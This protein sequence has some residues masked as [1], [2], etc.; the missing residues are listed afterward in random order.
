M[1]F[2]NDN[3]RAKLF[4]GLCLVVILGV[5]SRAV[6]IGFR[7]WDKYLGDVGYAAVFYLVVSLVW[8][9]WRG[10]AKA[11]LIALYV[12]TIEVFQMTSIPAQLNQSDQFLVKLFASI[13]LGSA[14]SWWD[15]LA[16]S[17]GIAAAIVVDQ[18]VYGRG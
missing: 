7:L 1:P 8:A 14:F 4:V 10:T 17:V 15:M 18:R 2:N 6:P 3:Y 16:Y 13:V 5:L 9:D 11:L 12:V